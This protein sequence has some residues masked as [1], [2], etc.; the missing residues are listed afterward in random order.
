MIF[1]IKAP[2]P[3]GGQIAGHYGACIAVKP[4]RVADVQF[5]LHCRILGEKE[6]GKMLLRQFRQR[7]HNWCAQHVANRGMSAGRIT[8]LPRQDPW[9]QIHGQ[10]IPVPIAFVVRADPGHC[11]RADW[12]VRLD[13]CVGASFTSTTFCSSYRCPY[14]R[15]GQRAGCRS[16]GRWC[17]PNGQCHD[18]VARRTA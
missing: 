7:S 18:Q 17:A 16:R 5:V 3:L 4:A 8:A 12:I 10:E 6:L 11:L 14:A 15:F 2:H 13:R 9:G 1:F